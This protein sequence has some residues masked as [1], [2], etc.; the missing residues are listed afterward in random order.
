MKPAEQA[1]DFVGRA[2]AQGR[3]RDEVAGALRAAGWA[4]AEV[5]RAMASWA[6]GGFSPPV[7]RPRSYVSAREAFVYGVLFV[8]L[9]FA[10]WHMVELG[11]ALIGMWFAKDNFDDRAYLEGYR[12]SQLRWSIAVLIVTVP[13]FLWLNRRQAKAMAADPASRRSAIRKW[14]GYVTLFLSLLTMAGNVVYAIYGLLDGNFTLQ[15][16]AEVALVMVVAGL[17]FLYY[18]LEAE[19]A[20]AT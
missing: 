3:S 9:G 1:A 2:L 15:F 13:L 14:V 12:L 11:S 7:P 20:D 6:E 16:A 19:D 10:T 17:V 18:R 5:A 4:E 8:A